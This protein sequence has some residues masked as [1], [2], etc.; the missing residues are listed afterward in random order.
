MVPGFFK[1]LVFG[2]VFCSLSLKYY[3][4]GLIQGY[5][6]PFL[7]EIRLAPAQCLGA[8]QFSVIPNQVY[9]VP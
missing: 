6:M 3:L 7:R 9:K 5:E 4:W 2:A 1:Y 8:L